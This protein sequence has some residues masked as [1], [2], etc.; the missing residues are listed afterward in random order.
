MKQIFLMFFFSLLFCSLNK[1]VSERQALRFT[2]SRVACTGHSGPCRLHLTR[3]WCM[4]Y[5]CITVPTPHD[6]YNELFQS[7]LVGRH[8]Q[9]L[10]LWQ[11]VCVVG[12]VHITAIQKTEQGREGRH[13]V[14]ATTSQGL[15]LRPTSSA[16]L[17]PLGPPNITRSS[18]G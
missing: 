7:I 5:F 2:E 13:Q 15:P 18:W 11:W 12:A 1:H 6:R 10:H 14:A 3:T 9:Q 8:G 4:G 16:G 17:H